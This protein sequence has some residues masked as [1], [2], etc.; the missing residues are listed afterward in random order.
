MTPIEKTQLLLI[1]RF[2]PHPGLNSWTFPLSCKSA[3][4]TSPVTADQCQS[5]GDIRSFILFLLTEADGRSGAAD[6]LK[7]S[8]RASPS[9]DSVASSSFLLPASQL[10]VLTPPPS[11]CL[12]SLC[13]FRVFWL[14]LTIDQQGW[15]GCFPVAR[16]GTEA[17]GGG[18]DVGAGIQKG[19]A[20]S[21]A[22][23]RFSYGR[24]YQQLLFISRLHK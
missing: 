21:T 23:W 2:L 9:Q 3:K 13:F 24:L 12:L 6:A 1:C 19:C 5:P 22:L 7:S 8:A 18:S 17:Q 10:E 20:L 14:M 4:T 15:R 11:Q 16:E